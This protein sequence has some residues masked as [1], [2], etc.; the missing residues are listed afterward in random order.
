MISSILNICARIK[1]SPD[2]Y[3]LLENYC[4]KFHQWDDLIIR[5]EAQGMGPLLYHHL[6]AIDS[7][8][9]DSFRRA[10]RLLYRIHQQRNKILLKVLENVLT[11]LEISNVRLGFCMHK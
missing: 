1:V 2:Q 4:E 8:I 11:L 10:L 5:A 7:K 9:P 3:N 6:C